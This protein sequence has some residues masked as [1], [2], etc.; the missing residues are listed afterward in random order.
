MW[1]NL[2]YD[3]HIK[4]VKIDEKSFGEILILDNAFP[5]DEFGLKAFH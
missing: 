4:S 3:V 2:S 1:V 5:K